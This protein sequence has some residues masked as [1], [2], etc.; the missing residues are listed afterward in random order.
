[1]EPGETIVRR[2]TIEREIG[3]GGMGT[4]YRATDLETGGPVAVK[5]LD[6]RTVNDAE[7]FAREAVVLAELKHP[8]IVRYVAHGRTES[9]EDFIAMEWLEGKTLQDRLAEGP[10]SMVETVQLGT[11]IAAALSIAHG[12]GVIHRDLKP[13]NLF[14]PDGDIA[15]VKLLDFGVA[16]LTGLLASATTMTRTGAVIGTPGYMAPEQARG[17]KELDARADLFSFGSVLFQCLTGKAPFSGTNIMAVLAKILLEE[18]P[19][20][21]ELRPEVPVALDELI[22]RLLAKEPDGRPES[23][24]VVGEALGAISFADLQAGSAY[25]PAPMR[26]DPPSKPASLTDSEQRLICVVLAGD[27]EGTGDTWSP[28]RVKSSNASVETIVNNHGGRLET[29][30]DGSTLIH[31]GGSGAATDLAASA[32]RC[33]LGL[34]KIFG[35][36]PV[37]LAT[38]RGEVSRRM[39]IGEV[40]DRAARTLEAADTTHVRIDNV[41]AGLL[42][43]RF[44]LGS[45][46]S[47]WFLEGERLGVVPAGR[48]LLGKPTTCVGRDRELV[49]LEATLEEVIDEPV[50]RSVVV[51]GGPGMGKSRLARELM[52]RLEDRDEEVMLLTAQGDAHRASSP[53]DLLAGAVRRAAGICDGEA[54]EIQREKLEALIARHVSVEDRTRVVSFIGEMASVAF[55]DDFHEGLEVARRDA[56]VMG[57]AM[58]GAWIDWLAAELDHGPIVLLLE[59]LHHGDLPTVRFVDAALKRLPESP[60]MVLALARPEMKDRFPQIWAASNPI[61]LRLRGLTKKA[62]EKLVRQVLPEPSKETIS[63]IIDRGEGNPFFI[64]ELIRAVDAGRASEL[65]DTVLGMVQ[66]RLDALGSAAKR[67]LRA[68]SV[69]GNTFWRGGVLALLGGGDS[70][71]TVS[72]WLDELCNREIIEK[73]PTSTFPD[74]VEYR[75]RNASMRDA[76]YAMLTDRDRPLGHR[77][78]GEW[79]EATGERDAT[80]LAG[81]FDRG[82]ENQKAITFY[83]RGAVQAI[84]ANDFAAAIASA[85]RGLELGADLETL[86]RLEL[87][88]AVAHYWLGDIEATKAAA[89]RASAH[90][91]QGSA[92]WYRAVGEILSSLLR[93]GDTETPERDAG[94]VSPERRSARSS[95][96]SW[97]EKAATAKPE[98]DAGNA[99]LICLARTAEHLLVVGHHTLSDRLFD[100]V[101]EVVEAQDALDPLALARVHRGRA[102]RSLHHGDPGAYAVGLEA[103]YETFERAGDARNACNERM[104]MG[105]AF[106]ELGLYDKAREALESAR[107]AAERMNLEHVVAWADNNLGNVLALSD[108]EEARRVEQRAI[109]AGIEQKDPRLE[110]TSRI[111]MSGIL[112]RAGDAPGAIAQAQR[113]VEL[114]GNLASLKTVAMAALARAKLAMNDTEAALACA[115]SAMHILETLGGL[116]EGEALVRLVYAETLYGAGDRDAAKIAIG[117]AMDRLYTRAGRIGDLAWRV[118]F[119]ECVPDHARTFALAQAWGVEEAAT[120]RD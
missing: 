42:E 97:V 102:R 69:F 27:T 61:E 55:P 67:V 15:R 40:I 62:T 20:V 99:Q 89:D 106:A 35:D 45:D 104:N 43:L 73:I 13:P 111:Y 92:G 79:L 29:L 114:L 120:L 52:T 74:E 80:V 5:R 38:G 60:L 87:S 26:V 9:G 33:A 81:H 12:R 96:E 84:E 68:A 64:E 14:L 41:S 58:K 98:P 101:D 34:R 50:A 90:L 115:E 32:A 51:T 48:T 25:F 37:V 11:R 18:A 66:A 76:A 108:L 23:A 6:I 91:P 63:L 22:A 10:L 53:F 77:L 28:E 21:R 88:R 24:D 70:T 117:T 110:G 56:M 119:L 7:R 1:M 17:A 57:D 47:G 95:L 93:S 31:F 75:F 103:A 109:D 113:A 78:A 86:G 44:E 112:H 83:L 54:A 100:K 39:P 116:E 65:P 85:D 71:S 46:P 118:T 94:D 4:V 2:F 19:R 16:R 3:A 36:A 49:T 82:S 8:G 107:T 59:D 72:E 30:M 105:F